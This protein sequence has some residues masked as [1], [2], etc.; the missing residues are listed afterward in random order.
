MLHLEM[1]TKN[2]LLTEDRFTVW[3]IGEGRWAHPE[4]NVERIERDCTD[5]NFIKSHAVFTQ[6]DRGF[7]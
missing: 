7:Y 2:T 4:H 5:G 3:C 1:F 6:T